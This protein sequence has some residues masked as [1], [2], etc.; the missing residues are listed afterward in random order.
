MEEPSYFG[1]TCVEFKTDE[2][3]FESFEFFGITSRYT[4]GGQLSFTYG[5]CGG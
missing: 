2:A 4:I 1:D 5:V 3:T